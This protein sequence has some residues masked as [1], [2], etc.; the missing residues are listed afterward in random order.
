MVTV[1][2]RRADW[3]ACGPGTVHTMSTSDLA[4]LSSLRAQ[5]E[6]LVARV[7][8]VGDRYRETPDSAVTN[9]LELAERSLLGA[10][11]ALERASTSLADLG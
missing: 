1:P 3:F 5:L 8:A 4:E 6:E 11:R 2:L 9:D 7:V 10:R